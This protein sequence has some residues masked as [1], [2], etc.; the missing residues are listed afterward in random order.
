VRTKEKKL[1]ESANADSKL[2]DRFH[3]SA[4]SRERCMEEHPAGSGCGM[5]KHESLSE[6]R[7]LV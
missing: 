7:V 5:I 2:G 1:R 3:E 4:P 6:V